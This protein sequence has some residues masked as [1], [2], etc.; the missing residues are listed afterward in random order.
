MKLKQLSPLFVVVA[1]GLFL[2]GCD[3]YADL[4]KKQS[5]KQLSPPRDA[6]GTGTIMTAGDPSN[7]KAGPDDCFPDL[8]PK[9]K[10][11]NQVLLN[12]KDA[13]GLDVNVAANY[14]P[15]APATIRA[16]FGY[17]TLK[18]IDVSYGPTKGN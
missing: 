10:E 3:P 16:T 11:Y 13:K 18:K 14:V 12:A 2:S 6:F 8:D 1:V 5:Y 7:I 17:K 9:I 15:V 4:L